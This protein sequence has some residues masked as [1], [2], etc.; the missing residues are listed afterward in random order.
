MRIGIAG[1]GL[2]G[3]LLA[4]LCCR[5]GY[6]VT[7]YD[8]DAGSG[9]KSCGLMAAGMLTPYAEIETA[10]SAILNV[11]LASIQLWPGLLAELASPVDFVQNG[12]LVLAY[13]KDWP[14]LQRFVRLLIEKVPTIQEENRMFALTSSQLRALEPDIQSTM[15][16][17]YFPTECHVDTTQLFVALQDSLKQHD[18][19]WRTNMVVDVVEPGTLRCNQGEAHSFDWVIDCRGLGAKAEINGLRGV[20][21]ELLWLHAPEVHLTRPV[22]LMHP[23]YRIYV[24]PRRDNIYIVGATEI[25]SEDFS[26][27][28]VRSTLELL[29]AT[30]SLHPGFSE[31]R[32]VKTAV[33]CRPA[34]QDNMPLFE[35]QPGMIR[36]NGL[37][38]HGYLLAPVLCQ[39]ALQ[40]IEEVKT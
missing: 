2:V 18:V 35:C 32:V 37:Y 22:R 7:L 10:E 5:N 4:W 14:D 6:H 28:S 24:V 39:K 9:E 8:K 13:T 40:A 3:R 20:R 29:S 17:Y 11:G 34:M 31:A 15:K 23:R 38:R 16:G 33:N 25:E 12:S 21:G 30:Y 26:P 27:I 1:A 36:I 19:V